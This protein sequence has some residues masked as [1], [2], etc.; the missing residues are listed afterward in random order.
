MQMFTSRAELLDKEETTAEHSKNHLEETERLDK[1]KANTNPHN[2]GLFGGLFRPKPPP[3]KPLVDVDDGVVRCP[4]CGWELENDQTCRGCGYE[5]RPES[6]ET[7]YSDDFSETDDYDSN[8]SMLDEEDGEEDD[9]GETEDEE[10]SWGPYG[11][12]HF[13]NGGSSSIFGELSALIDHS[14]HHPHL[15]QHLHLH[16]HRYA[17]P[18]AYTQP[19]SGGTDED[20]DEY[21]GAESQADEYEMD[22][23]IDDEDHEDEHHNEWLSNSDHSTIVGGARPRNRA[24]LVSHP[25]RPPYVPELSSEVDDDDE[26]NDESGNEV[27]LTVSSQPWA[28][29]SSQGSHNVRSSPTCTD[30]DNDE[31]SD[32]PHMGHGR[33]YYQPSS[34]SPP[35]SN[36]RGPT[37]S[38]SSP[39][40]TRPSRGTGSSVRHAITIDDSDEEQPVGP[41]RRQRR[42]NRFSPY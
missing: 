37:E 36:Q 18:W 29:S 38:S 11:Q 22:S 34:V 16:P 14:Y 2:G 19:V 10:A 30:A 33:V 31:D 25:P 9:F 1:D 8:D 5:Y 4:H 21:D 41:V 3:L 40:P 26:E 12:L 6:S 23:F 28:V 7:D 27:D 20:D 24:P 15:E 39:R 32:V 17:D 42:Q 35:R 13:P